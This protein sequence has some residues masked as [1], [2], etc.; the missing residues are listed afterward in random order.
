M[1][2]SDKN[3]NRTLESRVD[4]LERD[5]ANHKAAVVRRWLTATATLLTLGVVGVGA[6]GIVGIQEITQEITEIRDNRRRSEDIIS[7][8]DAHLK[9]AEDRLGKISSPA[10][11]EETNRNRDDSGN[12]ADRKRQSRDI[13]DT[14]MTNTLSQVRSTLTTWNSSG[15]HTGR[16]KNDGNGSFNVE[17]SSGQQYMVVGVCDTQC[18]DIDLSASV[19]DRIVAEDILDDDLPVLEIERM[20]IDATA[21]VTVSMWKCASDDGCE[22]AVEIYSQ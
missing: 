13:N 12:V 14:T 15:F 18:M 1:D 2:A 21:K 11:L 19:D 9:E 20:S 7:R 3:R 10:A 16:L 22:W 8:M 17:L 4:L 6:G 5:L